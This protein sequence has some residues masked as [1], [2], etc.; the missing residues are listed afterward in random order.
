MQ[1]TRQAG[2]RAELNVGVI[3]RRLGMHYRKNV[4]ALPGSPD[5]A[6][7]RG[8]WAIFVNGCYWHHHRGCKRA[9]I[10]KANRQFWLDKFH[11]NRTRDARA[12]RLLRSIGFKVVILWECEVPQS[13]TRLA[14]ILETSRVDF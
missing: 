3:L 9:T 14:K 1:R 13:G 4:R 6:N 10:P 11:A 5:F 8:K 2:T 7:A 12:I